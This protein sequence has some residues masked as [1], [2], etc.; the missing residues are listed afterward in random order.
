MPEAESSPLHYNKEAEVRS[1]P[2]MIMATPPVP[3]SMVLQDAPSSAGTEISPLPGFGDSPQSSGYINLQQENDRLRAELEI[4]RAECE[5][6]SRTS[7]P[8]RRSRSLSPGPLTTDES[9]P[10]LK[11]ELNHH[12]HRRKLLRKPFLHRRYASVS[13]EEEEQQSLKRIHGDDIE[14][15]TASNSTCEDDD[16]EMTSSEPSFC[17]TVW[18]RAGWLVGLLVLQS[19]S[20]F[21]ISRNEK[22]LAKHIVI[23]QFLTM[24]VGAGGNAG[25]Q[26]SVQGKNDGHS[27]LLHK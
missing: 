25:N 3:S 4:L 8:Q 12:K 14:T 7:L 27:S 20:S 21:I 2:P 6:L 26:S 19:L 16:D 5:R 1:S 15:A 23:V 18:D 10:C 22:L 9:E 13:Q 17:T 24:L 11:H